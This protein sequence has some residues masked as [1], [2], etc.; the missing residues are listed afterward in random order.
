VLQSESALEAQQA[1]VKSYEETD[2]VTTQYLTQESVLKS[3]SLQVKAKLAQSQYQI[4]QLS[5]TLDT[6][7]EQLN[8][9]LGRDIDVP[10]RTE[11]VPAMTPAEMDLKAARQMALDRRPEVKEAEID[12]HRADY[13]RKLSRAKYIPDVGAA[14]HY[15]DPINTEILPQ[16]IVSAGMELKWDPFDWGGRRDEVKQK[17]VSVQQSRY[18]LQETRA[19]VTLDVDNTFRKLEESRSM[20][21]V[22]QAGKVAADE[23]LREVN[24]AYKHS[25]VLLRDVLQ[26]QAAVAN[27][28]H[29]YEESLLAFWNAKALF[30]KAL[31]EE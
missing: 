7:K 30:E 28:D 17:D 11:A 13:D 31:G 23:K 16:N 27:A 9:L 29:D 4:V 21:A 12:T 1:L 14:I 6:Q 24:D 19:Q 8:E 26:Q 2:R 3:D 18:Q 22:A 25:A 5:D 15:L 20:L 10:F